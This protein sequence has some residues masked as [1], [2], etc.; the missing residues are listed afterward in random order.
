MN[1]EPVDIVRVIRRMRGGSQA[2]LV[3]GQNGL[4]YVA[5]FTGN[6]Q[7]TRTLINEWFASQLFQQLGIATPPLRVLRLTKAVQAASQDLAFVQGKTRLTVEPGLHLGS[8]CPVNPETHA[9][10]DFLPRKLLSRVANPEDFAKT[11]VLD[12]FL[13]QTD[14]RQALF[15]REGAGSAVWRMRA[16]MIDQG[17]T[18]GGS[19]WQLSDSPRQRLYFDRTVYSLCDLT[20]G[21][22]QALSFVSALTGE[23]LDQLGKSVP[24]V[25][26]SPSDQADWAKLLRQLSARK[27][28]LPSLLNECLQIL[29]LGLQAGQGLANCLENTGASSNLT[30][31]EQRLVDAPA[32][33]TLG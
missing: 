27:S 21:C 23:T 24:P 33:L 8:Q 1:R 31:S 11:L 13:G 29:S 17:W 32:L 14:A 5:K 22:E 6:P 7:G 28:Q 16:Y 25:W 3:E 9:L 26:F 19:T 10:F 12:L 20:A 30:D 4:F 2:H 18:L 15:V